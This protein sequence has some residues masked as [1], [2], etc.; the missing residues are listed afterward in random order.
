MTPILAE[1]RAAV[2]RRGRAGACVLLAAALLSLLT[3]CAWLDAKQRQLALRPT[4]GRPA[5][6]ATSG[7]TG[8]A[9]TGTRCVVGL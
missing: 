9:V 5:G 3:G 7:G 4:V 1:R 6:C 8:A 2:A